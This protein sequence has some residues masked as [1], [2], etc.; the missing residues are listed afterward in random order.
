MAIT[1]VGTA[2]GTNTATPPAHQAGDLF[3]VFAYRDGS[4]TAPTLPA[5]FTSV[6]TSGLNLNSFRVGRKFAA[7]SSDTIG[8]WTNATSVILIVLRGVSTTTPIGGVNTSSGASTTITYNSATLANSSGSS[9]VFAFA[10]HRSTN[11]AIDTVPSGMTLTTSVSD[12][13]DEAAAFRLEGATS[14][15]SRTSAVGGTSSGWIS[16]SVEVRAQPPT[17]A[18]G[19]ANSLTATPTVGSPTAGHIH[20]LLAAGIEASPVVGSPAVGQIHSLVA[21]GTIS[22]PVV[23]QPALKQVHALSA[24]GVAT[25]PIVGSPEAST[26][27]PLAKPQTTKGMIMGMGGM[28]NRGARA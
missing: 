25:A 28:M 6:N 22:A 26:G 10:G 23:E 12:A 18:V 16:S 11:V 1:L 27:P 4:N 3:L 9:W 20:Q 5:G 19:P 17:D 13:T 24:D 14:F 21:E 7:S 15:T 2:T 8:T